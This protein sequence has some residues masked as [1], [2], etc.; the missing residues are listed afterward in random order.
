MSSCECIFKRPNKT[1]WEMSFKSLV[2]MSCHAFYASGEVAVFY[3][4]FLCVSTFSG[5]C[6]FFFFFLKNKY[7]PTGVI[8]STG[9]KLFTFRHVCCSVLFH[10]NVRE[11]K[12]ECR[13]ATSSS[14]TAHVGRNS[15]VKTCVMGIR[16][17]AL[18]SVR[19]SQG[20]Y[21]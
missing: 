8:E 16:C 4:T 21:G 14:T 18:P 15:A 2:P 13:K 17:E 3:H 19:W 11:I 12:R 7:V 1:E 6:V 10:P 9:C 20:G 5:R